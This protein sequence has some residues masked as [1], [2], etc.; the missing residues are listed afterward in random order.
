ML[1]PHGDGMVRLLI[2]HVHEVQLHAGVKQTLA[3]TRRRFWITKGRSAVKD[4]V[5]KCMICR[6]ATARPFGQR[7]A[8]LPP[9]RTELVGPF[10][11]VGVDF[12]GP[13]LARS[14]GKPLTL[15]KT[16]V[17]VFTCMVVRAIHL[18]LVPEMTIDSFLRA[19]RRFIARI[20]RP[21]LLQSDNF[22]TFHLASR[23]LK[24][25]CNSRNSKVVHTS[26]STVVCFPELSE[27]FS[28]LFLAMADV[29][30]LH[31]IPNR[32]GSMALVF[33]GRAYK[34][35][36]T[37][38]QKKCWR[39]SKDKKGCKGAV[40][41]D[42]EVTVVI[43]GKDHVETC[44]ISLKQRSLGK[45]FYCGKVIRGIY[46]YLLRVPTLACWQPVEPGAWMVHSRLYHNGIKN[47]L[48]GST[49]DIGTYL[50][51]FQALLN[52]AAILG[53]NL[54]PQNIICDFE[55]ALIPAMQ[56][57]FPNTRVQDCYFHF[58]QAVHRK[59]G[60]LGLKTRYRTEEQ[61]K[62]KI[63]MLLA[64]AFLPVPQ[65]DMGVSLL[66]AG[67]T[68]TLAALFQYFRQ[69]WMTDERPPL[70]NV[71]NVNIR[72]NIHLEG[73]HN[74]LNRKAAPDS[75]TGCYGHPD[76]TS[77]IRNLDVTSVIKQNDHIESCPVDEHLI[78]K[79]EKRRF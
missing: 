56:G 30:E 34:L 66:E 14:D 61:R 2:Q 47:C 75:G 10:V 50:F 46:W 68:G 38:K 6:R 7:M 5:W 8:E 40:W 28:V 77:A 12:A 22:Q 1:L 35:K 54:N 3:A 58:C 79:M 57:Y 37:G 64:T 20:G 33:E 72:T 71:H 43:D 59:V 70:W 55:T 32:G 21:R 41:T 18:E 48:I 60:E 9:E 69:E 42:L 51:I 67:T 63:R 44:Q 4:V 36:H 78:Y 23:F 11:Y 53:V 15:L 76:S 27:L 25:L 65:V 13:V 45:T 31:L 16:Y 19:L 74:R 17:C 29:P 62:R 52:K 26:I 24:P 39:C 73:W 49:T